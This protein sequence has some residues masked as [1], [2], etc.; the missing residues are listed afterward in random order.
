MLSAYF[1]FQKE[2]FASIPDPEFIY[3]HTAFENIG[4][5][6]T[7]FDLSEGKGLFLIIGA[8]GIGKSVLLSSILKQSK[9]RDGCAYIVCLEDHSFA[10]LL[11]TWCDQLGIDLDTS[12]PA[13][14]LQ[15]VCDHLSQRSQDGATPALLLDNAEKLPDETLERLCEIGRIDTGAGRPFRIILA[16]RPEI[17]TRLRQSNLQSVRQQ[18]TCRCSLD[19]LSHEEIGHYIRHQLRV[20]GNQGHEPF[21]AE[22]INDIAEAS[23][24]VP[25]AINA[26][27]DTALQLTELQRQ[28]TVSTAIVE[29]AIRGCV[30]TTSE[31]AE[32]QFSTAPE[33]PPSKDEYS[34]HADMAS[35]E[36]E[37]VCSKEPTAAEFDTPPSIDPSLPTDA[38]DEI[39]IAR[40]NGT[41]AG[42]MRDRPWPTPMDV[43]AEEMVATWS[44]RDTGAE[45]ATQRAHHGHLWL[46]VGLIAVGLVFGGAI[47][48]YQFEFDPVAAIWLASPKAPE[49]PREI[50][51]LLEAVQAGPRQP[52]PLP[53]SAG[54]PEPLKPPRLKVA[55]ASGREDEKIPLNIQAS[56]TENGGSEKLAIVL[57]GLPEKARLSAGEHGGQDIWHL[58]ADEL[59]DLNLLLPA[60]LSGEFELEV[61]AFAQG[62]EAA[63]SATTTEIMMVE[64]S[65]VADPPSLVVQDASG[66]NDEPILIDIKAA[67]G[68]GDGSESLSIILSGL[69]KGAELSTGKTDATGAWRLTEKQLSDLQLLPPPRFSG[70]FRLTAGAIALEKDG[71]SATTTRSLKVTVAAAAAA[72]PLVDS[73][74]AAEIPSVEVPA[75]PKAAVG[76]AATTPT[77]QLAARA[78]TDPKLEKWIA[79]G[80]KLLEL[81]DLAAARLFYEL[82]LDHGFAA[83]ATAIGKTYDPLQLRLLGIRSVPPDRDMAITWYKRG[84]EAGDEA[85]ATLLKSLI[86]G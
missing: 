45:L 69:P 25:A 60:N 61:T 28:D 81:G 9:A 63:D 31:G 80:D 36:A 43:H 15:A 14:R 66:A 24:G 35:F 30:E 42:R 12:D 76:Q 10:A 57:A 55:N 59:Q 58:T 18:I 75:V 32:A 4:A 84:I 68:D 54:A 8:P 3:N 49:Q 50:T 71:N 64:V 72:T 29:Q 39:R 34:L 82:A 73:S 13:A 56:L 77:T 1:G 67:L 2:P 27:C 26:L 53:E 11:E 46:M 6:L 41:T 37:P 70:E 40:G 62:S 44:G 51:G 21:S 86:R 17:D 16:A 52:E 83:A 78:P 74:V 47:A 7:F 19:P 22:A 5:G 33:D 85:A 20:A 48:L 65:G 38:V 79:R 23:G